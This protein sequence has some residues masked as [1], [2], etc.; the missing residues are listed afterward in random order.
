MIEI[1]PEVYAEVITS[2]C[3]SISSILNGL[4]WH[5]WP[6]C[7]SLP[8]TRQSSKHRFWEPPAQLFLGCPGCDQWYCGLTKSSINFKALQWGSNSKPFQVEHYSMALSNHLWTS[9]LVAFFRLKQSHWLSFYYTNIR[10]ASVNQKSSGLLFSLWQRG[11]WCFGRTSRKQKR[12]KTSRISRDLRE[13]SH[14]AGK[15]VEARAFW[16]RTRLVGE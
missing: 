3:F 12:K 16:F 6:D 5:W 13:S 15:L 10:L 2:M 14:R 9:A 7:I 4:I 11:F 1:P 8:I